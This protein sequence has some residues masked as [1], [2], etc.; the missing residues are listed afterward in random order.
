MQE[1]IYVSNI[2][3]SNTNLKLLLQPISLFIIY[4][5]IYPLH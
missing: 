5:V 2:L 1:N 3:S 4:V